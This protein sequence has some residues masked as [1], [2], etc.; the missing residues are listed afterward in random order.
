MK[1]RRLWKNFYKKNNFHSEIV[2]NEEL[3]RTCRPHP[4]TSDVLK[5]HCNTKKL[6]CLCKI[7]WK[8]DFFAFLT[9]NIGC[10]VI[11]RQ[12]FDSFLPKSSFFHTN[13]HKFW[14]ARSILMFF[15][16]KCS[17]CAQLSSTCLTASTCCIVFVYLKLTKKS[18][19]RDFQYIFNFWFTLQ[20]KLKY[21]GLANNKLMAN[22]SLRI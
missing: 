13:A 19:S 6:K 15:F 18:L 22:R 1:K 5:F 9:Q 20:K 14:I 10:L 16:S 3:F 21:N 17:I 7:Y 12:T 2:A 4:T 11:F 8:R